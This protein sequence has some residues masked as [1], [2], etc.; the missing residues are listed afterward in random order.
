MALFLSLHCLEL[1]G[2][3]GGGAVKVNILAMGFLRTMTSK[4]CFRKSV[5]C[6][7]KEGGARVIETAEKTEEPSLPTTSHPSSRHSIIPL[8]PHLV[9]SP[10]VTLLLSP[11]SL[12]PCSLPVFSLKLQSI[13]SASFWA[14]FSRPTSCGSPFLHCSECPPNPQ[15]RIFSLRNLNVVCTLWFTRPY[16]HYGLVTLS[17][18]LQAPFQVPPS[19]DTPCSVLNSKGSG[20]R[21]HKL[22][23]QLSNIPAGRS[24]VY[25]LA[26]WCLMG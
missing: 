23:P 18:Y 6:H 15:S 12:T 14:A 21:V 1:P 17:H 25:Y 9:P 5:V 22:K 10:P 24:W 26:T 3:C 20:A 4:D 19:C 11:S 16:G 2:Q 7:F 8:H 13:I